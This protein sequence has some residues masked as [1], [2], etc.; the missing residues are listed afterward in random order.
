MIVEPIPFVTYIDKVKHLQEMK[1]PKTRAA[2]LGKCADR[3]NLQVRQ[4]AEVG[5][6]RGAFSSELRAEFPEAHLHLIDPWRH[7]PEL[8]SLGGAMHRAG[9]TPAGNERVWD[10][11]RAE[12]AERFIGDDKVT[13]HRA[14]SREAA[15]EFAE[16]S[17]DLCY[18]DADH[19]YEYVQ[20]DIRLW[21]PKVKH[22]AILAGHD[23]RAAR[24]RRKLYQAYQAVN[25]TLGQ[26]NIAVGR[27]MTWAYVRP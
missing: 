1:R 2:F 25:D 26:E 24:P 7:I 5:V 10:Q 4:I 11:C 27:Q 22:G 21:L 20:E 23:Y 3:L 12:V 13:L 16:E 18:I 6:Y 15:M 9:H 14:L 17:L 8:S 19:R